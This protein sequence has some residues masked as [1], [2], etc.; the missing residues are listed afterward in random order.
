MEPMPDSVYEEIKAV[1]LQQMELPSTIPPVQFLLCPVGLV[2]AGK[3]TV[4]KPLAKQLDLVRVSGDELRKLIKERGY[5]YDR[6]KPMSYDIT[7][8]FLSAGYSLAIDSD[9]APADN[10]AKIAEVARTYHL[11][12]IWI[13]IDPPEEFILNKLSH[14]TPNWLGTAEQM[15][16]NYHAR[17][18][19][20][21]HLDHLRFTYTFDTSRADLPQQIEMGC[22]ALEQAVQA[23]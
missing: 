3:T 5:T 15:V 13:H 22:E 4:V 10:Q 11:Q 21:E 20:H 1:Y 16:K 18:P 2:G 8:H 9:C 19:L 7:T 6:M 23:Y 14:L 17:K 12:V